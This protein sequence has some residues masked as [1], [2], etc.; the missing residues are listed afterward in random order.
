MMLSG[1]S[2]KQEKDEQV[3]SEQTEKL[4]INNK[5]ETDEI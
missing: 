5:I 2:N 1:C 4:E 3:D